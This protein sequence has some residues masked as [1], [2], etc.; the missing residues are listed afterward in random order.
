MSTKRKNETVYSRWQSMSSFCILVSFAGT[1]Y[2]FGILSN[3]LKNNLGFTV[4]SLSFIASMGNAGLYLSLLHGFLLENLGFRFTVYCGSICIFFGYL[5]I[6]LA[7]DNYVPAN[8]AT[9]SISYFISQ[10]GACFFVATS[11]AM[12]VH[13]FP[14]EARGTAIGLIKGYFGVSSTALACLS[15]GYFDNRPELYVLFLSVLLPTISELLFIIYYI[16]FIYFLLF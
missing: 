11:V 9:I 7:I 1:T 8:L 15:G 2:A 3:L 5:Y 12:S 14:A 4:K 10:I 16:F 6:Y 13:L